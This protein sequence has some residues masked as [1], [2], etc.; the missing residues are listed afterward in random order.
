M[1]NENKLPPM[2][3]ARLMAELRAIDAEVSRRKKAYPLEPYAVWAMNERQA[4]LDR[5]EARVSQA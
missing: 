2:S 3:D 4:A 1:S 5:F